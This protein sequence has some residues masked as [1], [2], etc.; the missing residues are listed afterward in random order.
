[1]AH[2]I[3][4]RKACRVVVVAFW[5]MPLAVAAQTLTGQNAFTDYTKESPGVRRKLTVA[6]LPAPFTTTSSDNGPTLVERPK[7]AW[8][9]GPAGFKV[10]LYADNLE[11]PRELRTA[12][13]G[14]LFLAESET[15]KI[16]VFRGVGRTVAPSSRKFSRLACISRSASRFIRWA[17]R[18]AGSTWAIRIL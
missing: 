12:P 9:K 15:G 4:M 16:R 11:N 1:M 7:D 8:P 13:N 14:D 5:V 18:R 10:Q 2:P 6:D 17:I 3:S